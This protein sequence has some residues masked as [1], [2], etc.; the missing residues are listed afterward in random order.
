MSEKKFTDMTDQEKAEAFIWR[1][2]LDKDNPPCPI[3][4]EIKC[5]ENSYLRCFWQICPVMDQVLSILETSSYDFRSFR[6]FELLCAI[7]VRFLFPTQYGYVQDE[8]RGLYSSVLTHTG[9]NLFDIFW[10]VD[11]V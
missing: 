5:I 11:H 3:N 4:H 10:S 2:I 8:V 1:V 9:F 6:G 7:K